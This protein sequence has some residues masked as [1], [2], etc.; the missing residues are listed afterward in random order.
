MNID[1]MVIGH[2]DMAEIERLVGL[3]TKRI[4]FYT[5]FSLV[6]LPDV[7]NAG[8]MTTEKRKAL[9][10]ESILHNLNPSDHVILLDEHGNEYTSREFAAWIEKRAVAGVRRLV[11]VTGGPFGFSPEVYGR[12]DGKISLSK[13]TFSHQI[14]RAI[15]AEQLYRALTIIKGDP[16]H[17]D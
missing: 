9:E 4:G 10:G 7:K 5:R 1:L 3:Y 8:H 12:A 17:N 2:T 6:E 11:F 13:M 14:V 15:F 16:Y